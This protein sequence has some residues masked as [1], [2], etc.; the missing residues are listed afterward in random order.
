MFSVELK[1]IWLMINC[2]KRLD[3]RAINMISLCIKKN[4]ESEIE[5]VFEKR[6]DSNFCKIA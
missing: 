4:T 6:F 2:L 5:N 3:L 1:L